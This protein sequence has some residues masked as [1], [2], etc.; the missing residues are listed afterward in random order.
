M[1]HNEFVDEIEKFFAKGL[2]LVK[3]KNR[4]SEEHTSELQSH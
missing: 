2:S 4:R 1:K 3:R